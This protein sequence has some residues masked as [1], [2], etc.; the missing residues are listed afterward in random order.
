MRPKK[1][2]DKY[3]GEILAMRLTRDEKI[4]IENLA[5]VVGIKSSDWARR[6][7]LQKHVSAPP[8]EINRQAYAEL[9]HIGNNL[10]QA[11]RLAHSGG[12]LDQLAYNIADLKEKINVIR[13]Q[14]IGVTNDCEN[15]QG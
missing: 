3:R 4:H 12:G 5:K 11:L 14:L 9:R 7:A 10:N 13:K 1:D 8:P 15:S 6:A 2:D